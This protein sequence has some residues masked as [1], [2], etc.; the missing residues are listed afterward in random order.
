MTARNGFSLAILALTAFAVSLFGPGLA[1]ADDAAPTLP[2]QI[3][4]AKDDFQPVTESQVAEALADLKTAVA[5]LER[6]LDTA[7]DN[8]SAWRKT[9]DVD[10]LQTLL[11]AADPPTAQQL[12]PIYAEFNAG[13]YGLNLAVF[14]DVRRA[15]TRYVQLSGAEANDD[16][17]QVYE[18][19]LDALVQ[20]VEAYQA[21]PTAE[22]ALAIGAALGALENLGQASEL[23]AAARAELAQ[24]NLLVRVSEPVVAAGFER[25]VD[26]V[27]PVEDLI[28]GTTIRGVGHTV[29]HTEA[30]LAHSDAHAVIDLTFLGTN[31]SDTRGWNGP[32]TIHSQGR[33]GL[34]ARTRVYVDDTGLHALPTR[35]NADVSSTINAICDRKGRRVVE[36]MAW[37]RAEQQKC[38]A[39]AIAAEH[40]EYRTEAKID[41]QAAEAVA[42]ANDAFINRF[43]EPLT[44]RGLFPARLDFSSSPQAM[45]TVWLQAEPNQVA[46]LGDP[47]PLADNVALGIRLHESMVNNMAQ[48]AVGGMTVWEELIQN[49]V[50]RILGRLPDRLRTPPG[51]ERWG[52]AFARNLPIELDVTDGGFEIIIRGRKYH[53]GDQPHPG[54]DVSAAYRIESGPNGPRAVRQGELRVFPPNYDPE[55]DGGLSTRQQVIRTLLEKRFDAML[56]KEIVPEAIEPEGEWS[57]LGKL[58]LAQFE[59][60]DGWLLLGWRL[61][62]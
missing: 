11:D 15:M 57:S 20:N 7:P 55:K 4:Q 41:A 58:P 34:A 12:Q 23:L 60:K 51:E 47:P 1:N 40:A 3:L 37:K 39:E 27:D 46:A 13:R 28:L 54:M 43:R 42:E 44:E 16:F 14:A 32:V 8:G 61:P 25:P 36:R 52:I 30:T 24:P 5:R 50:K 53:K 38:I 26:R 18:Q 59:A 22:R 56:P 45:R 33:T 9:L 31:R 19:Y 49:D 62:D 17:R 29:G 2:E 6:R 35:A 10:R 21:E 48:T